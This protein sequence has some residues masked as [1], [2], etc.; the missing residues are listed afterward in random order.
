MRYVFSIIFVQTVDDY[1][2]DPTSAELSD[3]EL[4]ACERY[5]SSLPDTMLALFMT[6]GNGV[7]WEDVMAPLQASL[8]DRV[9]EFWIAWAS[10]LENERS[11][12]F[13]L[14]ERLPFCSRF[15]ISRNELSI[16][17]SS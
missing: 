6:I 10:K 1:I 14:P 9:P 11:A 17:F 7:G 4:L 12:A 3:R 2:M 13:G 5:F 8:P 15:K 16:R